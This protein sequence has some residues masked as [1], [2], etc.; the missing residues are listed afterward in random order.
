[1]KALIC[2]AVLLVT[3][4]AASA[5]QAPEEI[6]YDTIRFDRNVTAVRT[7]APIALDGRL[8][9]PAWQTVAPAGN[10]IQWSPF[11]GEPAQEPSDVYFL[12]DDSNLYVGFVSFD[13]QIDRMV[14]NELRE[15]FNFNDTDGITVL[16]DSLNDDRSGF[17]FGTNPAGAK[18]DMQITNGTSINNDWDGVW[19]VEVSVYDDRWVAEF[20]IPFK[21]LRFSQAEVQE[22]GLNLSRRV[23]R[24][25]EESL[26]TPVAIRSRVTRVQL[27]GQLDGLEDLSQGMNLKV[28]PY[29]T[30]GF[31]QNRT[32]DP[33]NGPSTFQWDDDYDG[34]VDL[35]YS[36]TPSMTL[37]ATV[38][39]DFAQVEADQQQVNIG[40]FNQFFPEKR[41]FFLENA[42][43]FAFGNAGG[44]SSGGP[45]V[46]FFS[47]RIGLDNGAPVPILGGARVSGQAGRYDLGL[48]AMK[49]RSVE[50]EAGDEL[51]PA[52]DYL[53]ARVKRNILANSWIGGLVTSRSSST[54]G[55]T[56]R[57]YGAD[58][59]FQ[60]YETRL[61]LDAFVL[62][63]ETPGYEGG[64]QSRR[65][66][67]GWSDD[68]FGLSAGYLT[69]QPN[70]RPEVG[71]IR[72]PDMTQ[73][74]SN[75]SWTPR[76]DSP[77]IR[78]YAVEAGLNFI[79]GAST[80][81]IETRE[82]SL[83]LS[84]QFQNNGNTY[85]SMVNT[86]ERL[87]RPGVGPLRLV[88]I[89]AYHFRR[90]SAG[91]SS[92]SS[93]KLSGSIELNWGGYYD[94][95]LR[96]VQ[97]S[98]GIKPNYRFNL[99]LSH[100]RNVADTPYGDFTTD[101]IGAR[102]IYGFSPRAF[103]NAFIQYNSAS[104]TVSS[105]LRF[106]WTHS[107]LS[108]LYIV[109]NDTRDTDRGELADRAIIV[110]FTNLFSF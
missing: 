102:M 51:S 40:R 75:V 89:G 3:V 32:L 105:N 10:F 94:G 62:G 19:E 18:R 60:F 86:M 48:L 14:V 107:P 108:D 46:P 41:D 57:V 54:D 97:S 104:N 7:T 53:V 63:S 59:R 4:P 45:I 90:Y 85:F 26:W 99:N 31:T 101:L 13:S 23:L 8:D 80:G 37:D 17:I 38:N 33:A 96:S 42:G 74:T 69:I 34:G 79:E 30:A 87:D 28:K 55:D 21:T 100:S 78:N 71:F 109:Y 84:I 50:D 58:A 98:L 70:F 88:P 20:E 16:I 110:K 61:N 83:N 43:N 29:V 91:A 68:E 15:D 1:M 36:L 67:G 66:Q 64:N 12:Y 39:T 76:I 44:N 65:L 82:Q 35:K 72:R 6:D 81:E 77:T 106:N 93:R 73:Y 11:H 24:L 56:N 92:D 2:L 22:W 25:N 27:A 5:Q 103:F 49:T 52:N 95:T 9:E 47:R